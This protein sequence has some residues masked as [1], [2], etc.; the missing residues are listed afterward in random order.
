[1]TTDTADQPWVLR[2]ICAVMT[3]FSALCAIF[4][5]IIT[6]GE[7]W[8]ERAE[9]TWPEAT[10]HVEECDMHQTSTGR[11]DHYYIDCTVSYAA[12]AEQNSTRIYSNAVPGYDVLQYPRY[13]MAP[14][15]A[16][17][18]AHP[19]GT[20]LQVRYDP[21]NHKKIVQAADYVPRGGPRTQGNLKM[22]EF[23]A[24]SFLVFFALVR[25]MWPRNSSSQLTETPT[26]QGA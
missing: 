1:M 8:Q 11:R 15:E 22:L 24:A 2:T 25:I 17:V 16:W 9:A 18:N 23:C 10:A 19:K 5:L 12:G 26:T 13:Q 14:Y 21:G 6:I 4:V 3:L 20:P 7:A